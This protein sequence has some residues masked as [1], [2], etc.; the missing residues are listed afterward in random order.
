MDGV[1]GITE[2]PIA[3]GNS[4]KYS[5]VATQYGTSWYHSHISSQYANGITGGIQIDGPST[6]PYDKDLGVFPVSDWFYDSADHI[7]ARMMD[8]VNPYRT[9]APGSP[10]PS[11]NVLFNGKNINP[12][13]PGGEYATVKVTPGKRHRLR[14][15]NTSADNTFTISISGHSMTVIETDFVP[16]QPYETTQVTLAVGMRYDVVINADK[17]VGA[18]WMNATLSSNGLC[19]TTANPYPA[20]ILS[21]DGADEDQLPTEPGT[22]PVDTFCGDDISRKPFIAQSAPVTEFE[23]KPE[24]TLAVSLKVDSEISR[25]FWE[26]NS[27][28]INVLWEK[29][30]LQYVLDKDLSFPAEANLI[31]LPE[32]VKWSFWVIQNESPVPHPMHLHGHDFLILGRSEIFPNPRDTPGPVRFDPAVDTARLTFENPLRRD[33]TVLPGFGWLVIAFQ[34]GTNPGAWG[35][36]CHIPWHMS[37]GLSVKF[38]ERA[39]LI[40]EVMDLPSI[41]ETCDVWRAYTP[42]NPYKKFDSGL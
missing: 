7:V 38:L 16:V 3:P 30:T 31:A 27:S 20:A 24:D 25:V 11:D 10:P 35:F 28:P 6:Y 13:G 26:V 22:P 42:I 2:C 14:L 23:P 5:F 4:K 29:P 21:Y 36:H 40:P 37:Q 32:E 41:K 9:G 19:G 18:Y 33:T 1:S 15:I 34:A 12:K 8:P 39:D 17:D